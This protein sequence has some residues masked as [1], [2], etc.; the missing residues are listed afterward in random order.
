MKEIPE[1]I[2]SEMRNEDV[3]SL[4]EFQVLIK[5]HEQ[6]EFD[7]SKPINENVKESLL[8]FFNV[9]SDFLEKLRRIAGTSYEKFLYEELESELKTRNDLNNYLSERGVN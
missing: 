4:E 7:R 9:G 3:M 6:P 8:T 5:C 1:S 2:K